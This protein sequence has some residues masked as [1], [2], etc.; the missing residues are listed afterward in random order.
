MNGVA[1]T[2]ITDAFERK[3]EIYAL[4]RKNKELIWELREAW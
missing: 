3:V 4:E 2:M 1:K